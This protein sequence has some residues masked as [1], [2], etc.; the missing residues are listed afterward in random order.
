MA[1]CG[2]TTTDLKLAGGCQLRLLP[3]RIE[4]LGA[5]DEHH[6]GAGRGQD[7]A[8]RPGIFAKIILAALDRS[9]RDGIDD[10]PRLEASLYPEKAAD[11]LEHRNR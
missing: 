2:S 3:H 10:Q 6:P 9:E 7:P 11:L 5:G 8:G 1:C 4:Q